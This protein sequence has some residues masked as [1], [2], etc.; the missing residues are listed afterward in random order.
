MSLVQTQVL[1]SN[2]AVVRLANPER[3]NVL[4]KMLITELNT[5]LDNLENNEAIKC[6]IITGTGEVFSGGGGFKRITKCTFRRK[7]GK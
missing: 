5:S 6:I 2:I 4:S 3:L 1:R 7:I